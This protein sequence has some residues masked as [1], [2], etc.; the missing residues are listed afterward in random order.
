MGSFCRLSKPWNIFIKLTKFSMGYHRE[1]FITNKNK[2]ILKKHLQ[3][4][5]KYV[6]IPKYAMR[7]DMR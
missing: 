5:K 4:Y 2:K 7:I 1:L 6:I 3:L